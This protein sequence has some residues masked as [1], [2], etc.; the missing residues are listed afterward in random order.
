MNA[1]GSLL[2]SASKDETVIVWSVERI[3]AG[4]HQDALITVLREHENQIDCICWAPA[5]ANLVIDQSDYNRS[6]INMLSL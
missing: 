6:Y 5:E 2:A 3:K 1:K 4:H